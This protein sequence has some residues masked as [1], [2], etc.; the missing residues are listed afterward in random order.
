MEILISN[1]EDRTL[2]VWDMQR[3]ILI[4]TARKDTDRYW[5]MAAH[6]TL[7]YFAAGYDN[8][9]NVFKLERER[10]ASWRVGSSVFYVHDSKLV[11]YDLSTKNKTTMSQIQINSKQVL[12]NQPTVIYYN[13]FNQ[14]AHD[15]LLNFD[16]EG[17]QYVLL[18]FEK[19][20][21]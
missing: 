20:L 7:N 19:D 14:G 11:A 5:I 4:H 13:M 18:E 10:H 21:R 2:R 17:G 16:I 8:G 9:M 6:P 1:S 15:V 3:R 12:L